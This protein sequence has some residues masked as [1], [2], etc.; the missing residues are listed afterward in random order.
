LTQS[1]TASTEISEHEHTYRRF[2]GVI[3]IAMVAH[4][5]ALPFLVLLFCTQ[6]GFLTSALTAVV[7][8]AL[9][10][11]WLGRAPADSRALGAPE[12]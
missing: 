9:G 2:M 8:L 7:I 3:R 12:Q 1:R 5:A 4:A 10:L 6:A 11:W